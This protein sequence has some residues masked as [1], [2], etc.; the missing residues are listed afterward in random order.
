MAYDANH[1]SVGFIG[2]FAKNNSYEITTLYVLS[3]YHGRGIGTKL[4]KTSLQAIL[5][6]N[7]NANFCLW[8]LEDNAPAIPF[9][10]KFGF[11][12][13]GEKSEE[14]YKDMQIV[15]IKMIRKISDLPS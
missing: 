5:G 4:M 11:V 12:C 9:Y 8:V 15:D 14:Y 13:N 3:E 6:F 1:E 7:I 10:K 2:Y